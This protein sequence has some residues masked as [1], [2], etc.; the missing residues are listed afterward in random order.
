MGTIQVTPRGE[1]AAWDDELER[2]SVLERAIDE[3]ERGL[4]D[5][6]P[7]AAV[8]PVRRTPRPAPRPFE[9]D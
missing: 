4:R 5:G 9:F 8:T 1:R 2:F 7:D 6:Q 3:A